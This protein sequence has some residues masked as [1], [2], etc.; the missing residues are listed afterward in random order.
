MIGWMGAAYLPF[1]AVAVLLTGSRAA[2]LAG[3]VAVSIVPLTLFRRSLRSRMLVMSILL[4][5]VAAGTVAMVVPQ[6]SWDRVL[7]AGKEV[8]GGSV[9]GRAII[10]AAGLQTSQDRP[11]LG[12]GAGAFKAAVR[13]LVGPL[14]SHNVLIAVLVEQG[15]VGLFIFIALLIACAWLV[16]GLPPLQRNMWA[17]VAVTWFAGVMSLDWQYSK[18]TWFLFALLAG[19]ADALRSRSRRDRA[20]HGHRHDGAR[21][22]P[23]VPLRRAR[24]SAGCTSL[25]SY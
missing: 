19:H 4:I 24:Q 3:I 15:M 17:V 7:T 22:Q 9:G 10:W 18:V 6:S 2:F 14:A 21:A 13:P 23:P 25:P 5:L 8:S 20:V 16:Y 1:A 12:V 11:W